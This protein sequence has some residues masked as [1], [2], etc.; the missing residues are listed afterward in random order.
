MEPPEFA[1]VRDQIEGRV[2]A[3]LAADG[4]RAASGAQPA[5]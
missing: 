4:V 1:R 2:R 3:L 5:S